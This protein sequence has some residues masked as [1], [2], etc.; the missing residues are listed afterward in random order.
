MA[1]QPLPECSILI[2]DPILIILWHLFQFHE[3]NWLI[4]FIYLLRAEEP[5]NLRLIAP[6]LRMLLLADPF[7]S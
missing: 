7:I 6:L 1:S 5:D 4:Y 2:P 3:F